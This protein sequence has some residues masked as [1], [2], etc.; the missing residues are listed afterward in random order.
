MKFKSKTNRWSVLT[1]SAGTGEGFDVDVI[2]NAR[3]AELARLATLIDGHSSLRRQPV[4][5]EMHY[6]ELD[7]AGHAVVG[8]RAMLETNAART[9]QVCHELVQ[10]VA[11]LEN[12]VAAS[13][14]AERAVGFEG[15]ANRCDIAGRQCVLVRGHHISD[16]ER[17]VV[18]KEGGRTRCVPCSG[19]RLWYTRMARTWPRVAGSPTTATGSAASFSGRRR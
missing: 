18:R 17:W 2:V 13:W 14:L 7:G 6:I 5:P 11:P 9:E 19:Q 12:V 4:R 8:H 3:G 15:A 10:L 1:G 16:G